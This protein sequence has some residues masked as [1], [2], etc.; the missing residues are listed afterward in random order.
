MQYYSSHS[1][2]RQSGDTTAMGSSIALLQ[3]RF[4]Q[5]EKMREKR[6]ER[7]LL[8]LFSESQQI[9]QSKCFEPAK[10]NL[11]PATIF[12]S[13]PPVQDSLSLGLN[14]FNK[15]VDFRP[16]TTPPST[17]LWSAR[18]APMSRSQNYE[19]SDDGTKNMKQDF[20]GTLYALPGKQIT[21]SQ[22][23][24]LV[25]KLTTTS[26]ISRDHHNDGGSGVRYAIRM[27]PI[28]KQLIPNAKDFSPSNC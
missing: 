7:E 20:L 9:S 26:L 15:H 28:A 2:G 1:L 22:N 16:M 25:L 12:P 4:R 6:E 23:A 14:L 24:N 21:D 8:R 18:A 5:L 17:N 11:Q 10:L 3:E 27:H 19:K 13:R